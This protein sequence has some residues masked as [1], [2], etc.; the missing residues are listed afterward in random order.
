MKVFEAVV[1]LLLG[2]VCGYFLCVGLVSGKISY[3]SEFSYALA[4]AELAS[5]PEGY[6]YCIAIILFLYGLK[7]STWL[8]EVLI[9]GRLNGVGVSAAFLFVT[10]VAALIVS[11]FLWL[12]PVTVSKL[13]VKPDVDLTLEP[14]ATH[15]VLVVLVLAIG[16]FAFYNSLVDAIYWAIAWNMSGN[17]EA[18]TAPLYLSLENRA[19]MWVTGF[20]I[21]ASVAIIAKARSIAKRMLEFAA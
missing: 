21:V 6:W 9:N 15:S 3:P 11:A 5:N 1:E 12:F 16:L 19:N 13:I 4:D 8:V 20:E 2:G 18:S 14:M 17:E 7:Q 10:S